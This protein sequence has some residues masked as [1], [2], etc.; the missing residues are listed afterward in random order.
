M[1]RDVPYTYVITYIASNGSKITLYNLSEPY[2]S[3]S[4]A[5]VGPD[6]IVK[7]RSYSNTTRGRTTYPIPDFIQ[8][9]IDYSKNK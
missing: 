6:R 8:K 4:Y 9:Q 3:S 2:S 1:I 5:H 7:K